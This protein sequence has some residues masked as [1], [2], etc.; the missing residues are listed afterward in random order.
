[1]FIKR[2]QWIN[3]CNGFAHRL[4]ISARANKRI[5]SAE[6]C[7][8]CAL[9][10]QDESRVVNLQSHNEQKKNTCCDYQKHPTPLSRSHHGIFNTTRGKPPILGL[11]NCHG[12]QPES[13][14]VQNSPISA[15]RTP[16]RRRATRLGKLSQAQALALPFCRGFQVG[17]AVGSWHRRIRVEGHYGGQELRAQ[18]GEWA[19]PCSQLPRAI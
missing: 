14:P 9:P 6:S 17:R 7:V 1:M 5:T 15:P 16:T 4:R 3:P 11:S 2:S 8:V 10:P 12:L 13:Y 19:L 18:G